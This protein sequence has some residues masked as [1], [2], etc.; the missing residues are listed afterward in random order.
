MYFLCHRICEN[1]PKYSYLPLYHKLLR[2]VMVFI[3]SKGIYLQTS[4]GGTQVFLERIKQTPDLI[5]LNKKNDKPHL[6]TLQETTAASLS[7]THT[8]S[9]LEQRYLSLV[10]CQR[11]FLELQ[12]SSPASV[13]GCALMEDRC[14][15]LQ[16]EGTQ[17][18]SS[19]RGPGQGRSG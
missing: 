6:L 7:P 11:L 4:R 8:H 16:T 9:I 13:R 10:F 15:H 19:S 17:F 14:H 18:K 2:I 5:Y 12:L 3:L 1:I